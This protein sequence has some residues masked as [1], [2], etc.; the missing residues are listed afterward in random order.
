MHK[1]HNQTAERKRISHRSATTLTTEHRSE[2]QANVTTY[3]RQTADRKH[4][5]CQN[6]SYHANKNGSP[7]L[8]CKTLKKTPKRQRAKAR[9]QGL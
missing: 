4:R 5:S 7:S 3:H 9:F 8:L 1:R 2:V 6:Q